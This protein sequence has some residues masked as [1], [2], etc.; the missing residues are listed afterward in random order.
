M[1]DV[2]R[3][4]VLALLG[5]GARG[6]K[7]VVGVDLVRAAAQ[8]G[9]LSLVVLA[10]DASRHSRAKVVPLMTAKKVECLEGPTGAE[11][12]VAVGKGVAAAVG[13]VDAGLANGIRAAASAALKAV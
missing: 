3:R 13:V 10:S 5:L 6:R 4:R 9:R 8:R 11:I 7:V 12:G 1:D 2:A